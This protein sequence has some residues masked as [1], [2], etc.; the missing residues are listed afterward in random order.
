MVHFSL[1]ISLPLFAKKGKGKENK[2]AQTVMTRAWDFIERKIREKESCGQY[3]TAENYV[4][5]ANSFSM[6]LQNTLWTFEDMTHANIQG[7]VAWM[8]QQ[9]CCLNT[10]SCYLK[11]MKGLYSMAVDELSISDTQP[12]KGQFL[13]KAKTKKRCVTQQ[14]LDRLKNLDLPGKTSLCMARDLFLFGIYAMGMPF[15]D[16]AFLKTS[17]IHGNEIR[18]ARHKTGQPVFISIEPCMKDIIQRYHKENSEFVF[19]ILTPQSDRKAQYQQYRSKLRLYNYHLAHLSTMIGCPL[20]SYVPRHTW[21]S[22]AY[23]EGVELSLISKALGHTKPSTTLI[24]IKSLSDH[25]LADAN[26]TLLEKI[27]GEGKNPPSNT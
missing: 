12:F 4:T 15:I 10:C 1:E 19:P 7:Y 5:V 22:L 23:K 27:L 6:F 13:G 18:Y 25:R 26:R 8:Q 17:Q 14:D 2:Q 20:S 11:T 9:G 16:I 24:Y 3:K 21:A